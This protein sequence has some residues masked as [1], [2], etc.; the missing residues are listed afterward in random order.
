MSV[1]SIVTS[2]PAAAP[3]RLL[4]L[5]S[6]TRPDRRPELW[7]I[8]SETECIYLEVTEAH[9]V[10]L[11]ELVDP[12]DGPVDVDLEAYLRACMEAP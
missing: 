7:R 1:S 5:R 3:A 11:E 6:A 2:A 4:R 8:E 10:E 12:V 9:L